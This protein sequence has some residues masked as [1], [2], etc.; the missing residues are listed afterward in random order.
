MK[1]I[2]ELTAVVAKQRAAIGIFITLSEP[3]SEMI[4]EVKA[5]DPY[6]M[7]TWNHK[8]PKIQILTIEQLLRGIRADIPPTSSA[9]EQALIAK[10]HQARR[11]SDLMI[12]NHNTSNR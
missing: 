6:V 11:T 10:R 4:K 5:T 12:C 1:D 2:R 8:Y 7:K 3:T 9:F